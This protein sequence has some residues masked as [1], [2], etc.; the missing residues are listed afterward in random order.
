MTSG[1]LAVSVGVSKYD[2]RFSL[3]QLATVPSSCQKT[4][5]IRKISPPHARPS[6][7]QLVI[8]KQGTTNALPVAVRDRHYDPD[9][10]RWLS[11]DPILFDGGDTNLY[12]YVL[13]DPVN[14]VDPSGKIALPAFAGI[15]IGG[16]MVFLAYEV[17]KNPETRNMINNYIQN[18][19]W[20]LEHILDPNYT[21]PPPPKPRPAT[22]TKREIICGR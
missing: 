20:H 11:K 12:G 22:D 21:P 19:L 18:K 17:Y 16:A 8:N 13:N 7:L 10:G 9:L 6:S 14:L 3:R 5:K 2:R 4:W 1:A 15:A